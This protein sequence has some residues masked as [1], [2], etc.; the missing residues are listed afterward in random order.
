MGD[1]KEDKLDEIMELMKEHRLEFRETQQEYREMINNLMQINR[2]IMEENKIM[3]N[4]IEDLKTK[5]EKLEREKKKNNII[6]DGIQINSR[7]TNVIKEEIGNVV[8]TFL[9]VEMKMNSVQLIGKNKYVIELD[10]FETKKKIMQNK[11]KLRNV[12]NR[13]I[14]INNDLTVKEREIQK[15]IKELAN[16]EKK[17]GNRVMMG[18]RKLKINN[19]QLIWSDQTNALIETN[20]QI[21]KN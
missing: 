18:Y 3:K 20:T 21:P 2:Q 7:D 6:V 13:R 9:N 16:I 15:Q 4:E 5:I 1:S 17:K 11:R 12:T 14:F 19:K 10:N 8:K